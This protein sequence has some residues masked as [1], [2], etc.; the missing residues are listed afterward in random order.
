[1]EKIFDKHFGKKHKNGGKTKEVQGWW[2]GRWVE[3]KVF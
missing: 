1:M 2:V 3:A